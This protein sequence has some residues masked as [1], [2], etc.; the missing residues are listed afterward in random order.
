MKSD[1]R[2]SAR[3]REAIILIVDDAPLDLALLHK[4]MSEQGYQTFVATSGERGLA[5]AQR[6]QPDLILLDVVMPN[7]DGI[8]TCR[9][10]KKNHRTQLI[11][12]IFISAKTEMQD[13]V[14]GFD[15]GA[16]DY[17]SK[18]LRM[19]EV[20]V[21]VRAQLQIRSNIKAQQEQA[22]RLHNIV[23]N[24]AEGLL[25]IEADGRIQYTN[26]A[27]GQYLGYHK[28]ELT[29]RAINEL[30]SP[31][32]TQEYLD[33]FAMYATN[34]KIAPNYG[35]REVSIRHRNGELLSMDLTLTP[36]YLRQPLYIGLLHDITHH[37]QSENELQRAAYF[38]SLTQIANRRHFDNV[39]EKEWQRAVR[40]GGALS[41][42]VLDIDHFKLYN[43]SLGHAAG[44]RCLQQVAQAIAS[45]ACR[46]GD[47]AA[48]YGGEEF[49]VLFADTNADSAI[50][51]A[52]AIRTHI[53]NLQLP[54]PRS[55]TSPW[56]TVSIGVATIQ[57]HHLDDRA[58]LFVSADRVLYVAK[59]GGRNQVRATY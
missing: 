21:R 25:I 52:E 46:P 49:V 28:N 45:H 7:M 11:P 4:I 47:L 37:K 38:D 51:L 36:M 40:S 41:L 23:N 39:L 42:M 5:I 24:I 31:L 13:V 20:C 48:R 8:E 55:G 35:T 33:Y 17:I 18:P 26:P 27:C 34:P 1:C 56:I 58:T 43:D 53:E 30:F 50:N 14:A 57:P 9:K 22:E 59:E 54:H 2:E 32:I 15:V 3:R 16:V 10:L 6:V 19:A 29:G 12:V 44:D